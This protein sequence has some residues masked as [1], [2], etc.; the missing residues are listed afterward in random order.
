MKLRTLAVIGSVVLAAACGEPGTSEPTSTINNTTQPASAVRTASTSLGT[1]LV[2]PDGMTM[3]VFT[4]DTDGESVCYESCAVL[5]PPVPGDV[6]I[7]PGLDPSI[8]GTTNRTDGTTQLTVQGQP[9][10]LWASDVSPG[11]VTGQNVE[12]V[13]FVVD[14]SGQIIGHDAVPLDP[15]YDGY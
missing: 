9:L 6:P 4:L 8:F 5:W 12:G 7:G 10:Y 13:W 15:G 1:V 3:Y 14:A 2:D 11:D